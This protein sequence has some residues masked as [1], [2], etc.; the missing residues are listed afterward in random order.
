[1]EIVTIRDFKFRID[2]DGVYPLDGNINFADDGYLE[3]IKAAIVWRDR[4]INSDY[5]YVYV[6]ASEYPNVV[7]I[8][9]S[10]FPERRFN[11]CYGATSIINKIYFAHKPVAFQY[12]RALHIRYAEH[13]TSKHGVRMNGVEWFI[14]HG[15]QL[16]EL[17]TAGNEADLCKAMRILP[18][19]ERALSNGV[20]FN[21]KPYVH[22]IPFDAYEYIPTITKRGLTAANKEA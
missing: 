6:F 20:L 8:G 18:E 11:D 17:A 16:G 2:R 14:L 4:Y 5:A 10:N 7:K 13:E 19:Y 1:M 3:A 15:G 9:V 12:E 21:P 22:T